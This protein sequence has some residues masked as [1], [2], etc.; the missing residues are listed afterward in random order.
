MFSRGT[1]FVWVDI[2]LLS[3]MFL[4]G[5]DNWPPAECRV[6]ED[7][8]DGDLCTDDA[9]VN[10]SCMHTNNT[11]PCDDGIPC[12]MNDT[13]LEGVCSGDPL[14]ADGDSYVSDACSG[15]DCEDENADVYPGAPELCDLVDNQCPGD[16]GYGEVDEGCQRRI[17]FVT[18]GLYAGLLGGLTGADTKCQ[19]EADAAGLPGTY[20]AWL[21][22]ASTGPSGRFTKDA[23]SYV[24]VDGTQ[25]AEDW[26]GLTSGLLD[27]AIDLTQH[28]TSPDNGEW[29]MAWTNTTVEG[30]PDNS[31]GDPELD[32]C[33]WWVSPGTFRTGAIGYIFS[34]GSLWTDAGV[35]SY[36][37]KTYHLYCFQQ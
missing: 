32:C 4:M 7:C 1:A 17:V 24:L 21:S 14:D 26:I 18:D 15:T 31:S 28:G 25:V 22:D 37:Y 12:T 23:G 27:H 10:Q 8:D 2:I 6:A 35:T 30:D 11:E 13:C 9:C 34:R 3:G 20:K 36:C 29:A 16:T 5:Q 33:L 19:E